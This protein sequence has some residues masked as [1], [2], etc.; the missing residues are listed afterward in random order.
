MIVRVICLF[1]LLCFSGAAQA[2]N[3]DG[4]SIDLAADHVEVTSNFS[5]ATVVVFGTMD[6]K[7]DGLAITLKGPNSQ[8]MVRKKE[9]VMG[10][11]LNRGYIFFKDVPHFYSYAV[12]G[13]E[14]KLA[15]SSVLAQ[16]EIGLN[17][18]VIRPEDEDELEESIPFQEALIRNWQKTGHFPL[19]SNQITMQGGRL[20]RAD[21]Q[22]PS[23]IPTGTYK[24]SAYSFKGG[25]IV[26]SR[27][28]LLIVE[29]AGFSALV[30]NFALEHSFA[31]AFIML[32]I[33]LLTGLFSGFLVRQKK[34]A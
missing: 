32:L 23:N 19:N 14:K 25:K 34:S 11:W 4:F 6:T 10:M 8:V 13:D 17:A 29:Q 22:L 5:G 30:K 33:A 3:P 16:N 24:V 15:P 20:F 27:D 1:I 7:S 18:L 28:K 12:Y 9:N 21:F 2:Q 26:D 31:Y